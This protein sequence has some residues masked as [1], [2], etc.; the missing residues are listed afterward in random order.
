VW[1]QSLRMSCESSRARA[2]AARRI[3]R[4]AAVLVG[5][6]ICLAPAL[7]AAATQEELEARVEALAGQLEA[8]KHELAA[9]KQQRASVLPNVGNPGAAA[10]SSASASAL[11]ATAVTAGSAGGPTF[12]G[13]GE[14]NYSRPSGDPSATTADLARFVLGAGYRFDESTRFVSELEL[15]HAVSSATD[16]GEVEVE[17]A[18]IEHELGR[19]LYARAGLILIPS[20]TLNESHEPTRYY[21][22]FRNFVETAIIPSTWREG[23]VALQGLTSG[24]LRWDVG[25]TTGFDLSKWDATS[26]AGQQS[27]LFSV[28]QELSLAHARDLSGF[29]ALNYTG[30]PALRIGASLFSGGASQGQAGLPSAAVT[31]WEGHVRWAP[32]PWD[33]AGLY[34]RGHISGTQQINLALLGN[35]SLIPESFFGW[36]L[37]AACRVLERGNWSLTPFV[38]HERFNTAAGYADLGPGLTPAALSD[39]RVWTAGLNWMIAPGVVIKADYLNFQDAQAPNRFDLGAGYQF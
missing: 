33:L 2:G 4:A 23:G 25:V 6:S 27:P 3:K 8:V 19:A 35:R 13:Y 9:L 7:T 28:H 30:I 21:G 24:G 26:A 37:Q 32:G 5:L 14:L 20:G 22:V 38:R 34:A 12:F 29:G 1:G 15:E 36:Y 18:Y 16:V 31:L 17:Q 39:R 11:P 10:L